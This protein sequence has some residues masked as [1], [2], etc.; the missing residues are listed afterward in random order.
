[1]AIAI[2][3]YKFVALWVFFV[4]M[5]GFWCWVCVSFL[6]LPSLPWTDKGQRASR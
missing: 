4:G 5:N 3:F 2:L 1:M 6:P